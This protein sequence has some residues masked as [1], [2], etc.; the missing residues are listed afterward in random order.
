LGDDIGLL[1]F[2]Q[3]EDGNAQRKNCRLTDNGRIEFFGGTF[4]AQGGKIV[5][6]NIT[7]PIKKVSGTGTLVKDWLAHTNRLRTLTGK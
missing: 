2:K 4:L 3:F 5:T 7:C 6:K 1:D